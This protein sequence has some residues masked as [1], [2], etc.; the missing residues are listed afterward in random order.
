M[1]ACER[2]PAAARA[3]AARMR[4]DNRVKAV[5]IDGYTALNAYVPPKE[6]R[7]LV[8]IDPPFEQADEFDAARAGA[9]R[10][11]PQM[12]D[13]HLLLWYPIK[14]AREH[15]SLRPRASPG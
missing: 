11:A 2:E 4:G 10:R 1:I 6:R 15:A 5:A 9:G 14:D 12:A 13:R 7:G 3:L 8:L